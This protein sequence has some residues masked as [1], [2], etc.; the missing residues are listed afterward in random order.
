MTVMES[1]ALND[2][3][4]RAGASD[5]DRAAW[6]PIPGWEGLYEVS[7]GGAVRSLDRIVV[8]SHGVTR[9]LAGR[10]LRGS[11][12]SHGYVQVRLQAEGRVEWVRVHRLVALVFLGAPTGPLV[13]H[14]DDDPANNHV[15]NLA[16]GDAADNAR[17]TVRNGNFRNG[18][19]HRLECAHG[20]EYTPENTYL[21]SDGARACRQ[22][23]REWRG[24]N[25]DAQLERERAYREANRERIRAAARA[26]CSR[27]KGIAA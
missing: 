27:K 15:S 17:D 14:L 25:L 2:L 24:R 4:A 12:H 20:H 9:S 26:S 6:E 16:Y 7:D 3:M 1:Q 13:R 11:R 8:T 18:T 10:I 5:T 23:K 21:T 19:S 22:C